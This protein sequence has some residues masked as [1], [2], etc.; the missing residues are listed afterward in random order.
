M[1]FQAVLVY[2][3]LLVSCLIG[4]LISPFRWKDPDLNHDIGRLFGIPAT[5]LAGVRVTLE[6]GE[7]LEAH[8]PCVYVAN[9]QS[10]M[11]VATIG[12]ILPHRT[13]G[14]GKIELRWIPLFGQYWVAAGNILIRRQ[15]RTHSLSGMSQAARE[16]RERKVS[17]IIFPEGTRNKGPGL[18]P[19][20]KGAFHVAL[21]SQVPVVALVQSP[22]KGLPRSRRESEVRIRVLEPFPTHGLTREDLPALME[23]VH[24]RMLEAYDELSRRG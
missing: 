14:I 10:G 20:K 7:R 3:W 19:F 8:Q 24:A 6:H 9:H 15:S 12:S 4:L 5:W 11:D 16:I 18:L 1:P 22:L 2:G 13:L 17:V 21:E 23:R